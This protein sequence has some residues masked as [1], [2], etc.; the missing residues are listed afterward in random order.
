MATVMCVHRTMDTWAHNEK[1]RKMSMVIIASNVDGS[2]SFMCALP[3]WP[4]P[5][6]HCFDATAMYIFMILTEP[7]SFA[8]RASK[9]WIYQRWRSESMISRNARGNR[10]RLLW[11]IDIFVIFYFRGNTSMDKR[12]IRFSN[13]LI[14]ADLSI[15]CGW[16]LQ[17]MSLCTHTRANEAEYRQSEMNVPRFI[18]NPKSNNMNSKWVKIRNLQQ[19]HGE[20]YFVY[21]W[22]RV[23]S[24]ASFDS[25]EKWSRRR[26]KICSHFCF[27]NTRSIVA[28]SRVTVLLFVFFPPSRPLNGLKVAIS[29]KWCAM[30]YLR[31]LQWWI[32]HFA[33]HWRSY[34]NKAKITAPTDRINVSDKVPW[35]LNRGF[36]LSVFAYCFTVDF[37]GNE[38]VWAVR[39]YKRI[40]IGVISCRSGRSI[41]VACID[42]PESEWTRR[43]MEGKEN[44]ST[45]WSVMRHKWIHLHRKVYADDYDEEEPETEVQLKRSRFLTWQSSVWMK[46]QPTSPSSEIKSNAK[47]SADCRAFRM[48]LDIIPI[49][50]Y[51]WNNEVESV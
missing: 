45:R 3:F 49:S 16:L 42:M 12:N 14:S 2:H 8:R 36:C 38:R 50:V 46:M 21:R 10:A 39:W 41:A 29:C 9:W 27:V 31:L 28:A 15:R 1:Q 40:S 43:R 22:M 44:P 32:E 4:Q 5:L 23:C 47:N 30:D 51:D 7:Q 20:E 13:H 19:V 18:N 35:K 11:N 17:W 37:S 33:L 26:K 34:K 25:K 24:T 48:S 6:I